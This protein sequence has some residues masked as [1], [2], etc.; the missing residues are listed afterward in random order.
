MKVGNLMLIVTYNYGE[1]IARCF[2][3]FIIVT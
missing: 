3:Y 2:S 1:D